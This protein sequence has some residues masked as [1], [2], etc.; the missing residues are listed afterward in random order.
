[1]DKINILFL[2]RNH[3]SSFI[4]S[5]NFKQ[6]SEFYSTEIKIYQPNNKADFPGSTS[7]DYIN[8]C[9]ANT[10]DDLID[11][12]FKEDRF[13]FVFLR[14]D[15]ETQELFKL[16]II[17]LI[18]FLIGSRYINFESDILEF[19]NSVKYSN[20]FFIK[21]K[22]INLDCNKCNLLKYQMTVNS[23]LANAYKKNAFKKKTGYKSSIFHFVFYENACSEDLDVLGYISE[24]SKR[25]LDKHNLIL[26]K[27]PD[28][29]VVDFNSIW[30]PVTIEKQDKFKLITVIF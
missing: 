25:F 7:D 12:F 28:I 10:I 27:Q 21:T 19:I 24:E 16:D 18:S 30:K 23:N 20:P 9:I 11:C 26:D 5:F 15:F 2:G 13:N 3:N 22:W 8:I 1:M 4:E 29:S 14:E 17:I 6:S